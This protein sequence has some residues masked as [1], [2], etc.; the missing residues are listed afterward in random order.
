MILQKKLEG[1]NYQ[2]I[3]LLKIKDTQKIWK[4]KKI[5]RGM[6]KNIVYFFV[7]KNDKN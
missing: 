7:E 5:S 2:R 4:K 1:E 3:I 6:V